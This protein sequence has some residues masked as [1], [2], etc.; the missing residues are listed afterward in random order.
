MEITQFVINNWY[1][2]L[3]LVVVLAL[4]AAGPVTE[5]IHRVQKVS[6]AEAV[7]LINRQD[8]VVVDVRDPNDFRAGHITN[9]LNVPFSEFKDRMRELEKYK[10]RPLI[11][12]CR[13]GERAVKG[14]VMLRQRGFANV[15]VL[16]GGMAAWERSQLPL[17]K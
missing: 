8:G 12:T 1:L 3:A 2:F 16:A 14:A 13:G 4:L 10:Q 9:A 5:L 17:Q 6:P 7:Q 15:R 11:V